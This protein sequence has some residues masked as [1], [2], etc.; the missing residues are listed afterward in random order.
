[1][2]SKFAAL[3]ANVSQAF[4]VEI[5][6]QIT[7]LP[8][9]DKDGKKAFIEVL[10]TDSD[11]G[12]AFDKDQRA[13]LR[14]KAMKSR[15]G[16]AEP[17]DQLEENIQKCAALTKAWHLVDPATREVIDVP[18]TAENAAELYAVPGMNWLFVQVWVAAND[19]ANFMTRSS[20]TSSSTPSTSSA[21][22]VS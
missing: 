21:A 1:M 2:S 5:I 4:R 19:A 10:S 3:A 20:P 17:G 7:D 12:R 15:N 6:D 22:A 18:C 16:M 13:A 11:A 14:R 9:I 8:I